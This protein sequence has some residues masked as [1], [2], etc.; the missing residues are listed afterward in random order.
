M[1]AESSNT[2]LFALSP[3]DGRYHSRTAALRPRLSEYGLVYA[4]VR[5]ELDWLRALCGA[6][7][8]PECPP[9]SEAAAA[10]LDAIVKDFGAGAA[11]RIKTIEATTNHDIKAVEYYL[12]E[13]FGVHRE[14]AP[15]GEFIHFACTSEDINNLSWA[16]VLDES[17]KQVLVPHLHAI[18]HSLD[19]LAE[20]EAD[21]GMLARTHGQAATPTTLGKEVA[22]TAA[23][24][25][26]AIRRIETVTLGG[27]INGATGN[28]NAHV[29]AYPEV[30]WPALARGLVEGLGLEWRPLTTQIEPHD[31]TAELL[32]AVAAANTVLI[33]LC[34]DIW[35]YVSLGYFKQRLVAGEV[36]SSTMP[37][38]VNPID[39][40]NA[41]G[42]FGL[43]N[44][45]ARHMAASLPI[46]RMQ[47]DLTDSTT[48]RALGTLFGH[49]LVA[50]TSLERGLGK[51]EVVRGR[52]AR[53]LD[54]H[55]EVL[56]EAAQTLMRKHGVANPY[57]TLKAA[58]R[59]KAFD[60][61]TWQAVVAELPLPDGARRALEA[62]TPATYTGMAARLAR[63][64]RRRD[65][66]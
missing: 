28:F 34:R 20:A 23:R 25:M 49:T 54:S 24:L 1:P 18:L 50:L 41:E 16:L 27:K 33:D 42:N 66:G 38:K 10:A 13:C 44:A 36:G 48:Q 61:A 52:L 53:E 17:R 60:Q 2:P 3:L 30:D 15:Y 22:V 62:L 5:V 64:R 4:R 65:D 46:S 14:L 35:S 59:G 58:T 8:I 63:T 37:H 39:F 9:L 11:K 40:E 43:A 7:D 57:E 45:L 29:V 51:L 32:D 21:T 26:K 12:K 6:P 55:W 47:R 31:S 19:A 56:G